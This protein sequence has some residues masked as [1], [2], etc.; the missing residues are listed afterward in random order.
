MMGSVSPACR[1]NNTSLTLDG[2][3]E[4]LLLFWKL[5]FPQ[6]ES[7]WNSRFSSTKCTGRTFVRLVVLLSFKHNLLQVLSTAGQLL[8]GSWALP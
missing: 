8:S 3:P 4:F 6:Q 5:W 7:L 1:L 2:S